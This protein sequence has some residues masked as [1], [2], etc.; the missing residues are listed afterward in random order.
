MSPFVERARKGQL[1]VA[2]QT[3]YVERRQY[4]AGGTCPACEREFES[5]QERNLHYVRR[6]GDR[7]IT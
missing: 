5:A 2:D 1:P 4:V 6:H 3:G 7:R